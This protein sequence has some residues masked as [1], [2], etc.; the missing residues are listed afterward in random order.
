MT[1]TPNRRAVLGTA[2]TAAGL[3]AGC[4]GS[5]DGLPS[6]TRSQKTAV[7]QYLNETT[8]YDGTRPAATASPSTSVPKATAARSRHRPS[9]FPRARPSPGSGPVR[10]TATT[11]S[12]NRASSR[13]TCAAPWSSN[14][15]TQPSRSKAVASLRSALRLAGF[16]LRGRSLLTFVRSRTGVAGVSKREAFA[17]YATR[18][19]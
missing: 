2:A 12:T 5:G 7:D 19:E 14:S 10:G 1:D 3:L 11:W 15:E 17:S 16:E 9:A 13:A 8:N 4:S 6:A 18:V